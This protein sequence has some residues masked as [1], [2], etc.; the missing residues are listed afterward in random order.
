VC[1]LCSQIGA[2]YS[3]RDRMHA[4]YTVCTIWCGHRRSLDPTSESLQFV[5][6]F[7]VEVVGSGGPNKFRI[8]VYPKIFGIHLDGI[9]ALFI[10]YWSWCHMFGCWMWTN[11][12]TFSVHLLVVHRGSIALLLCR[13]QTAIVVVP[14]LG[15][16]GWPIWWCHRRR[17]CA[18]LLVRLGCLCS[19]CWLLW[20]VIDI[21]IE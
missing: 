20:Y 19:S 21:Y 16:C 2:A 6:V 9:F 1:K 12:L 11:G 8:E 4:W 14:M 18:R 13:G 17:G 15:W 7:P 10:V 3:S 5:V